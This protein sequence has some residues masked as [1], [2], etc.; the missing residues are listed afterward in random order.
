M[1]T[2]ITTN[3]GESAIANDTEAYASSASRYG[4]RGS[5]ATKGGT[6]TRAPFSPEDG[7]GRA[8]FTFTGS[9]A[10]YF[11]IW[12]VNVALSV[13]TLGVY[14]AWAKVRTKHYFYGH[15]HLHGSSFEY[16]ADP[17][18]ILKGRLVVGGFL[19][20]VFVAQYYSLGLYLG[21]ALLLLLLT[22]YLI[23][24][25]LKFRAHNSAYRNVRFGFT[26]G[27]GDLYALLARMGL[28][29]VVTLGF[30]YPYA[31]WRIAQFVIANHQYGNRRFA[32]YAKPVHY[33]K[34][35]WRAVA[36]QMCAA[37]V[38][39]LVFIVGRD[40]LFESPA[41]LMLGG[42]A[43]YGVSAWGFAYTQAALNNLMYNQLVVGWHRFESSLATL[44]LLKLYATNL[45]GIVLSLGLLIPWAMVRVARYRA[46]R[47]AFLGSA[48]VLVEKDPALAA[49]RS[50]GEAAADLGDVGLEF[51][52]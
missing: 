52:I 3:V 17:V 26:G 29:T 13:I 49:G 27:A 21:L 45:I 39:V 43:F 38:I 35:L 15:A 48:E 50:V 23:V 31:Q 36:L 11:R 4:T 16:L 30:G 10:E 51:G 42:A 37:F 14:S 20:L 7:S 28:L 5:D 44:G 22:P 25:G 41:A 34:I 12:I 46:E 8:P 19:V 6:E 32:W 2:E 40:I 18:S 24:Q 47:L 9:A 1:S 33:Y